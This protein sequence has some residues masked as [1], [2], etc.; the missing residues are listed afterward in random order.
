MLFETCVRVHTST[1]RAI[2]LRLDERTLAPI[3][4]GSEAAAKSRLETPTVGKRLELRAAFDPQRIRQWRRT[5][6]RLQA[7]SSSPSLVR[8]Y[9]L[10]QQNRT[11]ASGASGTSRSSRSS[12][13]LEARRACRSHV[14]S[15]CKYL[16]LAE[17]SVLPKAFL[18]AREHML[19]AV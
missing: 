19:E 1:F 13:K 16:A 11:L 7:L 12:R 9:S 6:R 8:L 4:L 17:V 2:P 15:F 18:Q 5:H 10:H 14:R 3:G